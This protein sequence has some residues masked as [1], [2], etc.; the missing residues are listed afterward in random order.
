[1]AFPSFQVS[2]GLPAVWI[3]SSVHSINWFLL[4]DLGP[5]SLM[6]W[7]PALRA[8]LSMVCFL[9]NFG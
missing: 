6:N 2:M 8:A 3:C 1:M 9:V 4:L 5:L 7:Y